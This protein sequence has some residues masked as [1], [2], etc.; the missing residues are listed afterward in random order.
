MFFEKNI[1]LI[2]VCFLFLLM[3]I[4]WT[5]M[6]LIAFNDWEVPFTIVNFDTYISRNFSSWIFDSFGHQTSFTHFKLPYISLVFVL[7][8]LNIPATL[9]ELIILFAPFLLIFYGFNKLFPIFFPKTKGNFGYIAGVVYALSLPFLFTF[10]MFGPLYMVSYAALPLLFYYSLS[11]FNSNEINDGILFSIK[12]ILVFFIFIT[13]SNIA[14]IISISIFIFSYNL[15]NLFSNININKI[16]NFLKLSFFVSFILTAM[17]M[18]FL[19]ENYTYIKSSQES[20]IT[21]TADTFPE[22]WYQ[23]NTLWEVFR[24]GAFFNWYQMIGKDQ[25]I[26]YTFDFKNPFHLFSSFFIVIFGLSSILLYKKNK[27]IHILYLLA[28]FLIGLI[29]VNGL[30]LPF[31]DI[32]RFLFTHFPLFSMFRQAYTK[33]GI[34]NAFILSL[35]FLFSFVEFYENKRNIFKKS[36]LLLIISI[37]IFNAWPLIKNSPMKTTYS[38]PAWSLPEGIIAGINFLNNESDDSTILFIPTSEYPLYDF[39]YLGTNFYPY[40]LNKRIIVSGSAVPKANKIISKIYDDFNVGEINP[41]LLGKNNIGYIYYQKTLKKEWLPFRDTTSFDDTALKQSEYFKLVLDNE[42]VAIYKLD[43]KYVQ[44]ILNIS[45]ESNTGEKPNIKKFKKTLN[46]FFSIEIKNINSEINLNFL[47]A[48]NSNWNL[49]ILKK[50]NNKDIKISSSVQDIVVGSSK[51]SFE[52][53]Q[54]SGFSNN[55][56]IDSMYIKQNFSKDYYTEYEDGSIDINLLLYFKPQLY[57]YFGILFSILIFF[58]LILFVLKTKSSSKH[59][60]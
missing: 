40:F 16:K 22:S 31:R 27:N 60:L 49:I 35:L 59:P 54:D 28:T 26:P 3:I 52:N 57:F 8:K 11:A 6:G 46:N 34:I 39:G 24:L 9:I 53:I 50:D 5:R 10:G 23:N 25:F 21:I 51:V 45:K 41:N 44:P 47:Q 12:F 13:N 36:F 29:F 48:Y 42:D 33:I 32:N 19:I 2:L 58:I 17:Y 18:P 7:L 14:L 43:T 15:L 4:S 55:W 37:I 38:K 1:E 20:S 56:V 30:N